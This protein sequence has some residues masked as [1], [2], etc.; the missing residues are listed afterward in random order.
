M[1]VPDTP[2]LLKQ[3]HPADHYTW[4][5]KVWVAILSVSAVVQGYG[6][7]FDKKHPGNRGKWTLSSNARTWGGFDSVTKEAV[8]VPLGRA[9]RTALTLTVFWVLIHWTNPRGR[10]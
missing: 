4:G 10:F 1:A 8:D 2:A 5:T 3:K 6:L 7:W 9:R